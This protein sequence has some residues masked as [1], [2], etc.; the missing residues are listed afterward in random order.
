[1]HPAIQYTSHKPPVSGV[2]AAFTVYTNPFDVI[3]GTTRRTDDRLVCSLYMET[4][5]AVDQY[6]FIV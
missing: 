4:T 2:F 6:N 3:V 5:A 1:M